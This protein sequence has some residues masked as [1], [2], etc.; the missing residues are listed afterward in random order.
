MPV[1]I[2]VGSKVLVTAVI[3]DFAGNP[4]SPQPPSDYLMWPNSNPLVTIQPVPSTNT[5]W[6]TPIGPLGTT[7]VVV[8]FSTLSGSF[9]VTVTP[10]PAAQMGFSFGPVVLV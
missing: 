10:G 5:A 2:P 7:S 9:D 8:E 4:L 1:T 6:V 3:K